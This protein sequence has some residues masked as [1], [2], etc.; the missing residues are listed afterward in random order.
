MGSAIYLSCPGSSF[1]YRVPKA[2]L[3]SWDFTST[4]FVRLSVYPGIEPA[5]QGPLRHP[6]SLPGDEEAR[7]G[8]TAH[9]RAPGTPG[10]RRG[11]HPGSG[12][13]ILVIML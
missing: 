6:P 3:R 8:K 5:P 13:H 4:Y 12:S 2:C 11:L 9:G 10:L 1:R 7:E